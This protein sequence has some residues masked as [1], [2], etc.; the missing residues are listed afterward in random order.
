MTKITKF[1]AILSV[2]FAVVQDSATAGSLD[3]DVQVLAA[4]DPTTFDPVTLPPIDQNFSGD[5]ILLQLGLNFTPTPGVGERDFLNFAA[6]IAVSGGL[7]DPGLGYQPSPSP[8]VDTSPLPGNQNGPVFP[9]NVDSAAADLQGI[10][11]SKTAPLSDTDNRTTFSNYPVEFGQLFLQWD[12]TEGAF[13][14]NGSASFNT[15]GGTTQPPSEPFE[16]FIFSVG[17]GGTG[18][19][20]IL[21]GTPGSPGDLSAALQ[22]AFNNRTSD[23]VV[24]EDAIMV[25]NDADGG[26]FAELGD[27]ASLVTDNL[28][29]IDVSLIDGTTE[30]KYSLVMSG[31]F[32]SLDRGEMITGNIV[33]TA[34]NTGLAELNYSFSA[35]I[36]EPSTMA[37]TSLAF[38]GLVG[39]ARRR[40]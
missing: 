23:T 5:P 30:G 20:P 37:L 38:V 1:F 12:G 27:I 4:L 24:V 33:I 15:P 39:F 8:E 9:T 16:E 14:I 35:K 26:T 2:T 21:A 36:P 22:T 29:K 28:E 18:T 40:K 3:F 25:M 32:S 11:L 17:G 6:N 13:S 19:D 10:I 34:E 7:T 31:P